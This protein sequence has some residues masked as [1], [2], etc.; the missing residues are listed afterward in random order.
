MPKETTEAERLDDMM[1]KVEG[2]LAKADATE[3]P[4]EAAVLRANAERIM[5]KYRIEQEDL[6]KRGDLKVNQFDILYHEVNAYPLGGEFADVYRSLLNYA[7]HHTGCRLIWTGYT[8]VDG[9]QFRTGTLVGYEADIRYSEQLFMNARLVFADR[10]EPKMDS[11][12]SNEA[13]VYRMR[14]AGMERIRI[15]RAMGYGGSTSATAKVTRQ[16]KA[17]CKAR[18]EDPTALLGKGNSVTAFR[19]VYA[20][21]FT[22]TF[23]YRL[24]DAHQAIEKEL[25]G[26][27]LVLHGR[28]ERVD[29]AVYVKWPYLR[30]VPVERSIEPKERTPAQKARDEKRADK[31]RWKEMEKRLSRAGQ[32]GARAGK[33]AADEVVINKGTPKRRLAE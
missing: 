25:E 23:W 4:G 3:F 20:D 2:L 32:A 26:G 10:M 22:S 19:A 1:R 17:E 12:L 30:P 15:A 21:E 14:M 5:M 8:Y 27:G 31:E 18:G 16:F 28:K 9:I 33:A 11:G 29:E 7:A 6:I 24:W 13:N